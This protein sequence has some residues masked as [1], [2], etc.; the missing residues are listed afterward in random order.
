MSPR[1]GSV[2]FKLRNFRKLPTQQNPTRTHQ[3]HLFSSNKLI[4]S[5]SEASLELI[6]PAEGKITSKVSLNTDAA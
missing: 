2:L 6:D 3:D 4:T 5:N 1:A